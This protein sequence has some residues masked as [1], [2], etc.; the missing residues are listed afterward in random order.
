MRNKKDE[1]NS[2]AED[3]GEETDVEDAESG[4]DELDDQN[5]ADSETG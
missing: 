3:L 4:W 1:A 5:F 2:E